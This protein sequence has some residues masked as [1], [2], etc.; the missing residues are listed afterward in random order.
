M[1]PETV[2]FLRIMDCRLLEMGMTGTPQI[3]WD[4]VRME[5]DVTGVLLGCKQ[6]LRDSLGDV[7]EIQK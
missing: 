4:S 3:P 5:T 1:L 7:K 6:I 2:G